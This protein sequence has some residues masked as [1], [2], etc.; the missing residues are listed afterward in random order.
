MMAKLRSD[1]IKRIVFLGTG[2]TIPVKGRGKNYRT[3]SSI[4]ITADGKNIII[5]VT[6]MVEE[7]LFV[8][9]IKRVDAALITHGHADAI[10]GLHALNELMGKIPLYASKQTFNVIHEH[11][12]T[13]DYEEHILEPYKP[14]EI[15][16]V[17]FIPVPVIHAEP[18]PTGSKFPTFA[19]RFDSILYAEDMEAIPKESEKYFKNLD[20]LIID[21]AMYFDKKIRGHLN[22]EQALQIIKQYK[23]KKAILTQ[24][25]RTYPD[26]YKAQKRVDEYCKANDIISE[27]K[28]AYDGMVIENL[29]EVKLFRYIGS[30]RL[31]AE[32]VLAEI[33]EDV[34]TFFDP[35]TGSSYI[36]WKLK[37]RGVKVIVNDLSPVAYYYSKAILGNYK[38]PRE[39]FDKF[40]K[41]KP[42]EGW[43][44]KSKLKRPGSVE[45][46]KYIDGLVTYAHKQKNPVKD[47]LLAV[48]ADMIT[49]FMGSLGVFRPYRWTVKSAVD[50]AEASY[51]DII[52]KITSG[53]AKVTNED[54]LNMDI[55][56]ADVIFFDPPY[57]IEDTEEVPYS[58]Q[59]KNANSI[60]MQRDFKLPEFDRQKIPELLEKLAKK[61]KI[62]L[63]TT[64]DSP[65]VDY[66][67]ILS[68]LK[69][70]VEVKKLKHKSRGTQPSSAREEVKEYVDLLWIAKDTAKESCSENERIAIYLVKPH[71]EMIYNNE[72]KLI[73]KSKKF[74]NMLNIDLYLV[75]DEFC[76]GIIKLTNIKEITLNEFEKLKD[77]HRITDEERKKWWPNAEKLY[78]YE[79]EYVVRF[80]EPKPVE[81]PQGAQTFIKDWQFATKKLSVSYSRTIDLIENI[82]E[83]D[84]KNV[85]NDQLRDDW[86]LVCFP[87]DTPVIT[88]R[89]IEKISDV[90]PTVD[91]DYLRTS[92]YYKGDI[93]KLKIARLG[94]FK[95]TPE[96]PVLVRKLVNH[97]STRK[98][99]FS[100]ISVRKKGLPK[101]SGGWETTY[102]EPEWKL[103]KDLERDDAV[104]VP[105]LPTRKTPYSK[106]V[107]ELI[108]WYLAEG[109]PASNTCIRFS[110]STK[111]LE[112][113][114]RIKKLAQEEF[115]ASVTIKKLDKEIRVNVYSKQFHDFCLA[116]FSHLAKNKTLPRWVLEAEPEKLKCMLDA[117]HK[118][119]GW[120]VNSYYKGSTVSITLAYGLF[121]CYLKI[122]KVPT[123]YKSKHET[124]FGSAL[125]YQISYVDKPRKTYVEDKNFYYFPIRSVTKEKFA[126]RVY[127]LETKSHIYEV[128]FVVHNCAWYSTI[129]SGKKFKFTKD[130][131]IDLATKILKEILRRKKAGKMKWTAKPEQGTEAY[132]KLW[133][134]VKLTPE[135]KEFLKKEDVQLKKNENVL[136]QLLP[137]IEDHVILKD[138]V[139]IV[140]STVE[141]GDGNDVDVL[142]RLKD[143]DYFR[144]A[145]QTL[146]QKKL[147]KLKIYKPV[148]AFM[149]AEGPHD[150]YIPIYDLKLVAK[151][152]FK[153]VQMSEELKDKI[154]IPY[155][156]QKPYGSAFN[157][158]EDLLDKLS[159]DK[160]YFVEKKFNG[161]HCI[162]I[163]QDDKVKIFSEQK[164][165]ITSA[166]KTL[167]EDIKKL[168]DKDFYVDG[169][170]VP[171]DK[172]GKA[173]GRRPL[174]KFIGAVESGKKVDDSNIKLHIW[175]II[176]YDNKDLRSL[177][178]IERKEYLKKL[179]LTDR[180]TDTP[181]KLVKGKEELEKAIKWAEKLEGSEGAVVK[182]ADSPYV[183]D[184]KSKAW[185][186]YHRL[187]DIDC[188][189]LERH[190]TKA[191]NV[192][193]YRIG[194]YLTEKEAKMIH[195]DRLLKFRNKYVLDLKNTFNTDEKFEPGD[196]ISVAIEDIWR[197]ETS[198][199]IYYSLH[200]PK[201]R[202][203]TEKKNTSTL[204]E[205]DNLVTSIG[206]AVIEKQAEADVDEEA[207][208]TRS[209]IARKT[210]EKIWHTRY[211]KDGKGEWCYMCH[212]RGLT[213]EEA[214]SLTHKGL[215]VQGIHSVHG[216]LRLLT[217]PEVRATAL[218]GFTVFEGDPK[219][220]PLETG[221]KLI[222]IA[223]H[224][225]EKKIEKLQGAWKL[226]EPLDWLYVAR[227]K[228]YIS[229][230]KGP[231]ATSKSY[232]KFFTLDRGTFQ[233]G[234]A[235]EHFFEYFIK[236][237]KMKGRMII[238]YAPIGGKRVWLID[239][240]EDQTP[241]A[242]KYKLEDVIKELKKKK[243]KWLIWC[244]PGEKPIKI[245]VEKYKL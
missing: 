218:T 158:I 47:F 235:K 58:D 152:P 84:P 200:K 160:Q 63:V 42:V 131:V 142:I 222:Y 245:D 177:P 69:K 211:P 107:F 110:L 163:K 111:E 198:E 219:D 117:W 123:L 72:K 29:Q 39:E 224:K 189:V 36:A 164:K 61:C 33:P 143:L 132:Q 48:C 2:P 26:H 236:G 12:K 114:E 18:F 16:G 240:P 31:M 128:P 49:R 139:S 135:E 221:S 166:F 73:V 94:T 169:E 228:P 193:N 175:D 45:L 181:Y 37:Q 78:A 220:I 205:L 106:G 195:P 56:E 20:L 191:K 83:Y 43:L 91:M 185:L 233:Q 92:R 80:P 93:I 234:V 196:I 113:A 120:T 148:H 182:E 97:K 9:N 150:S 102:A 15:F 5:D 242:E 101:E 71:A 62:L 77:L 194:I 1:K 232:A 210:W 30:K 184:E 137:E 64:S 203:I 19:Y 46:R 10:K 22:T 38:L 138:F 176:Y 116:N 41:A 226:P 127:N 119:D 54:A 50:F 225:K 68:K 201:V 207:P 27:V 28:L 141:K 40:L 103:A 146:I 85:G 172:N 147:N 17:T 153:I 133:N 109:F 7:Q 159:E 214:E 96:H 76:Y 65:Y 209:E 25:G 51:R 66:K 4:L 173:L 183:F 3:N 88:P 178:L 174:M 134:E 171:Y 216:D 129:L 162:V 231:G 34:K 108:G 204:E 217:N 229:A 81:L 154:P 238:T 165:D 197:H 74:P 112:Y 151:K 115:N 156:P 239:F 98:K 105:K 243:Q 95:L 104:M 6:P 212:W 145:I 70:H 140:G 21:A 161:F 223:I 126:G 67:G 82:Y 155:L 202:H 53:E 180:I 167:V 100:Y 35:M 130:Q 213:K 89:G 215:L 55:P 187:V 199:G 170:L 86:R 188:V 186:K 241:Y 157:K 179:K 244:K 24:I 79:F 90:Q 11:Y 237:K 125:S 57:D 206:Y 230:P 136:T 14:V 190:E 8:N 227:K 121:L 122:G 87:A 75:D 208:D 60:L 99:V 192:Y 124:P 118:G 149:E 13:L 32:E 44:T 59:Y 52:K 144:R 23:P 168:S